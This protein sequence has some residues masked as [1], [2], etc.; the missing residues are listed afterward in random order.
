MEETPKILDGPRCREIGRSCACYNLRRAARS[1]TRLYDDFLR[2]SGL[3]TT[4]FSVL[5]TAKMRGPVTITKLADLTVTERTTLTRNLT[6][7]EKKGLIR[8]EP[9]LDRRERQ[10]ALTEAGHEALVKAIPLWETVQEHVEKGLGQDR[11][12]S[13]LTELRGIVALTR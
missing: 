10:V 1:I 12:I 7:L 2:P 9:G 3:K 6:I 8:I 11:L 13:F 5:M 4:Q